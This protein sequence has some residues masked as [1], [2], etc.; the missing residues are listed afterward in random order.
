[1]T[2]Q[3][4]DSTRRQ[5]SHCER[6]ALFVLFS[7]MICPA[8]KAQQ[9]GAWLTLP[10]DHQPGYRPTLRYCVELDE[11]SGNFVAHNANEARF[12]RIWMNQHQAKTGSAAQKELIQ[13]GAK[14]LYRMIHRRMSLS[15]LPDEE[16]RVQLAQQSQSVNIDYRIHLRSSSLALG[17]ELNF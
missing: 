11:V 17:F 5:L 10:A 8:V 3:H 12:N 13:L 14:A 6:C 1:M 9:T 2:A 7:L 15:Y 4:K 16:G